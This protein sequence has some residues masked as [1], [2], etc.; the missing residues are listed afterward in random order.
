MQSDLESHLC[1]A[2]M[3]FGSAVCANVK[4]Y[5][6]LHQNLHCG[7]LISVDFGA[8]WHSP[9]ELPNLKRSGSSVGFMCLD[10]HF[11]SYI[12]SLKCLVFAS[13]DFSE[14]SLRWHLGFLKKK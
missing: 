2:C 4:T 13:I 10:V 9:R 11:Y 5:W 7:K 14:N 12:V 3:F 8:D 6:G 1:L